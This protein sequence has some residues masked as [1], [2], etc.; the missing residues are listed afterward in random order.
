M[1]FQWAFVVSGIYGYIILTTSMVS[2]AGLILAI[3]LIKN[4]RKFVYSILIALLPL[5]VGVVS[6]ILMRKETAEYIKNNNEYFSD[7]LIKVAYDITWTAWE[8]GWKLSVP[9]LVI[10]VVA[11]LIKFMMSKKNIVPSNN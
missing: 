5:F 10:F 1:G 6:T 11:F 4:I 9:L 8:V 3:A 2:F 7:C